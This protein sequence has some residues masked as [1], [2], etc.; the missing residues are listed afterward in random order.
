V[1]GTAINETINLENCPP[2]ASLSPITLNNLACYN[3][4]GITY[5]EPLWSSSYNALQSQLSHNAG[6]NGT[7][8]LV[9]TYSHAIDYEDNGAG[10]GSQGTVF[11][12]PAMAR[13]NRGTAGYDQKHNL[14]VYGGYSLPFGPGQ[15]YVNQ[16]VLGEIVGGWHLNGAFSHTSG[17]PFAVSA[18]SNVIGSD[19]APGFGATYAELVAPYQQLS[20]HIRSAGSPVS[21]GKAWFNTASFA[22]PTEP[23]NTVATN[24]TNASPTLP[25]TG[26][27]QFRGPGVSIFNASIFKGFHIY[28]ESEFQIRVEAFNLLNHPWLNN[29]NATVGGGTFGYITSYGPPYSPNQGARS[30]Q[31]GGRFNF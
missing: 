12:Y 1:G 27:N 19:F 24:P 13:F 3:T 23:G 26:R 28:R 2:N 30:L 9:Y 31:F 8:G 7:V 25:N 20:G 15:A 22:N 10:S 11:N 17:L 4:G 21:G 29:P 16:G 6:K 18:N 5:T 14:Q